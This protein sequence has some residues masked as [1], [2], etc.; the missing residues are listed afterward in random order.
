MWERVGSI[1][2]TTMVIGNITEYFR[3]SVS[4]RLAM[5]LVGLLA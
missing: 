5:F 2:A 3:S 4:G 1:G